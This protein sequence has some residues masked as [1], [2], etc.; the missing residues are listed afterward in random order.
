MSTLIPLKYGCRRLILVGDPKQLPATV[1]S[2]TATQVKRA[3]V[4]PYDSAIYRLGFGSEATV[5]RLLISCDSAIHK[6][7]FGALSA[8]YRL[9]SRLLTGVALAQHNYEQSLFQRLQL[10]GLPV[11]MLTTQYRMNPAISVFPGD[12]IKSKNSRAYS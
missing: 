9:F 1:F 12:Y 5:I 3:L 10:A 2:E 8:I 4:C 11:R 7:G 6:L